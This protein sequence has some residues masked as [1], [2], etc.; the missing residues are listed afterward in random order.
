[1]YLMAS[2]I[3]VV[4]L[5]YAFVLTLFDICCSFNCFLGSQKFASLSGE[6]E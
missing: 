4:L 1:M 6:C 3:F 5:Q 2:D